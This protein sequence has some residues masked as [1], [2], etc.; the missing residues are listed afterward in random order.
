MVPSLVT[1]GWHNRRVNVLVTEY[2]ISKRLYFQTAIGPL[3]NCFTD[4]SKFERLICSGSFT[5]ERKQ[6][7]SYRELLTIT[8]VLK[9]YG[10]F[11]HDQAIQVNVDNLNA[12]R[13]LT[14]GSANKGIHNNAIDI[15]YYCA[16]YHIKLTPTG[17]PGNTTHWR[18][19]L[20]SERILIPGG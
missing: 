20:A 4:V 18:I 3:T 19:S 5:S 11:L 14:I 12:V 2:Q 8:L 13:S 15:F 7:S 17:F 16:K 6:S 9:S 1:N 10:K